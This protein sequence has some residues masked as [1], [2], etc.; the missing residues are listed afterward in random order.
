MGKKT[1]DNAIQKPSASKKMSIDIYMNE[2][3]ATVSGK[4]NFEYREK[5]LILNFWHNWHASF[6]ITEAKPQI[7]LLEFFCQ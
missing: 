2:I 5:L 6:S 3:Q 1:T 7:I 4:S